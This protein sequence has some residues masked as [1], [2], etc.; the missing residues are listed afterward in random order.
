[1]LTGNAGPEQRSATRPIH[2]SFLPVNPSLV[3]NLAALIHMITKEILQIFI[4][5]S[6]KYISTF[7]TLFSNILITP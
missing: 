2:Y 5:L 3:D 7:I 6:P 4:F 1:M